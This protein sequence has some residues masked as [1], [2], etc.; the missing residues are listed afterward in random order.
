MHYGRP[1]GRIRWIDMQAF[2]RSAAGALDQVCFE[3]KL[4]ASVRSASVLR[5]PVAMQ[6]LVH[7]QNVCFRESELRDKH[8]DTGKISK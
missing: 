8:A 3:I 6:L 7:A 4:E 1:E 5:L 2:Q